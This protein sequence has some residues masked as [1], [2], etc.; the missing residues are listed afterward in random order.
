MAIPSAPSS[1][2][3]NAT[4]DIAITVTWVDNSANETG[5]KLERSLTGS[6]GWSQIATLVA[7][8]TTYPDSG[9]SPSTT[10]YYRVR[11]YNADGDSSY[12]NTA[13]DTTDAPPQVF[14]D[15][16]AQ[17][18]F[19]WDHD[20]NYTS[21]DTYLISARGQHRLTPPGQSITA[22][23]GRVSECTV[24]MDNSTGRFSSH[25]A[26]GALYSY[27][28]SGKAYHVPVKVQI[29][30][31]PVGDS[32]SYQ[33]VFTGVARIPAEATLSPGQPQTITFDCRGIEEVLLNRRQRTTRANFASYHDN[34]GSTESTFASAV[35]SD[36]G[37]TLTSVL[38]AGMFNI[39]WP[40]LE[41]ES[42]V[43]ELWKLAAACGGRFYGNAYGQL[44]Y[45]N[46]THWLKSPHTTSQQ[47]YTRGSG[48]NNLV[49]TWN[50][51]ELAEE[52]SVTWAERDPEE[53]AEIYDSGNLFVPVGETIIVW[54][55]FGDPAYG[56]SALNYTAGTPGG[57]NLQPWV[58]VAAYYYAGSAKLT[59]QNGSTMAATVRVTMTGYL[60][61]AG[62]SKT[63]TQ[64]SAD[65]FWTGREGRSRKVSGNRWVQ[66]ESQARFL[67]DFMAARQ[68]TPPL[69]AKMGGCPG[70]PLR[71]LG[72]RITITD[73]E[74]SLSATDFFI[75]AVSWRYDRGGFLQDFEAIRAAD[76]H[77]YA[78]GAVSGGYFFLSTSGGNTL[79]TGSSKPGKLFF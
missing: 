24:V 72:D 10:Y 67:K 77:E 74:L 15:I 1:C 27:I 73:A 20:G 76:A 48:F 65:S 57:M 51:T 36:S 79:G 16:G 62:N 58:S 3:A 22:T 64:E 32:V 19:D 39:P 66:S 33:S 9:L 47:S 50:E 60:S 54:A 23:S 75:T 28:Q 41:N 25:N 37:A 4:S 12:S 40:W 6:G 29:S 78:G 61:S 17:V 68:E 55:D 49:L 59:I 45:E 52:V 7:N 14:Y 34:E 18:Y 56:I 63:V 2:T 26:A 30:A 13:N 53:E 38:D 11:A 44:V 35:L 43:E 70:N 21:E 69:F 5:F 8:V 71:T 46:A 31:V 42:I